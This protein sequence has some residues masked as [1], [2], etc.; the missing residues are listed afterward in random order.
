MTG[1][2]RPKE[3]MGSH[4]GAIVLTLAV[5]AAVPGLRASNALASADSQPAAKPVFGPR[6]ERQ[7][8]EQIAALSG[9][10]E[11]KRLRAELALSNFG[12]GVA[13]L[14]KSVEKDGGKE[15]AEA[16]KRLLKLPSLSK[17]LPRVR[18]TLARGSMEI[19]L[20]PDD[21]PNTVAHFVALS[22]KTFYDG[23]RF[24]R[25]VENFLVQG[26]DPTNTGRG[27][28]GYRFADEISAETLRLDKITVKDLAKRMDM[29]RGRRDAS[30][31]ALTLK[32]LYE[33]QGFTY[34]KGLSS[35]P[36]IRGA[37]AMANAGP[38]TNGSQF[39][40]SQIDCP[41]LDGKQTVFGQVVRGLELLDSIRPNEQIIRVE[42]L[43][44]PR[45]RVRL[46]ERTIHR[47]REE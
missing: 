42:V 39:F 46:S 2:H 14:L 24:H 15:A 28:P 29:A 43:E 38:N 40:I 37:V 36:V 1:L 32:E 6:V 18:L 20:F 41:W 44:K 12:P 47:K 5:A 16:A 27:G 35:H 19:L 10:D 4:H 21:A 13:A 34:V 33:K 22:E 7:I 8:A 31:D 9:D 25:V 23:L 30:L 11:A 3:L 17:P 26:G 45:V